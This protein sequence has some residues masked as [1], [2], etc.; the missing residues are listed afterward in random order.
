[1][2]ATYTPSSTLKAAKAFFAANYNPEM[3]LVDKICYR[4]TSEYDSEV[5]PWLGQPP[6]MS[7]FY[8][9]II[10]T[11][12][13]D[14]NYTITN[15]PFASGIEFRQDDIA[16]NKAGTIK[17]R[18]MQ[19][20]ET[21][22]AHPGKLLNTAIVNGTSST[23][24]LGYDGVE[25]FKTAHPVRGAE[26]AAQSNLLTGTGVTTSAFSVDFAAAKAAMLN[27]QSENGEPFWGNALT[28]QLVAIVPPA[29][30]RIARES[31]QALVVSQ[32]TNILL[33]QAEVIP[34][35]R[36]TATDVNDWYLFAVTP[37]MRPFIFQEREALKFT[38]QEDPSSSDAV[39]QRRVHRY[40]AEARYGLGYGFWQ[41]AI[42]TTNT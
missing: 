28:P 17:R 12:L 31:L 34:S 25:F 3:S 6:Q 19:L 11:G 37:T 36:L 22:S 9:E 40:K 38:G 1:M 2:S 42:K 32:T 26:S 7:Q 4:E 35:A 27:F 8:D 14:T 20:A 41:C 30:E 15:Y 21:A 29:L 16:D 13:S 5:Y 33:N 23:L 10:F 18:I 39:F 24:G